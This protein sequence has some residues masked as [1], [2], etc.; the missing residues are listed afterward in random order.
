MARPGENDKKPKK[1][2]GR[3]ERLAAALRENLRRRKAQERGRVAPE[4][5]AKPTANDKRD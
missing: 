3:G 2:G 4:A 1:S 5:R